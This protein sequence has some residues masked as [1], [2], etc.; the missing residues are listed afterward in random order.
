M[1]VGANGIDVEEIGH[2]ELA[3]T[4]FEAAARQFFEEREGV[5]LVLD[6]VVAQRE[7]LMDHAPTEIGRLAQQRVAHDVEIGVAGKAETVRQSGTARFFDVDQELGGVVEAH[8]GV[9]RHQAGRGFLV[10][11]AEAMRTAVE[12]LKFRMGL[13]HEVGLAREPEARVLEMREHGFGGVVWRRVGDRR[14]GGARLLRGSLG[15]G[16]LL[17]QQ[18]GC[19]SEGRNGHERQQH[20]AHTQM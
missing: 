8:A 7:N 3:E 5:A 9:E 17:R 13:K 2:A 12:R 11:R 16:L 19:W 15:I 6:F 10:V 14:S 20:P 4:E 18:R 1:R